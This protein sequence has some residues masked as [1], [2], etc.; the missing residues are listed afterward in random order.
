MYNRRKQTEKGW[1]AS[2]KERKCR[3]MQLYERKLMAKE[4]Q[5]VSLQNK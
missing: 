3:Y 1:I 2:G 5:I 4:Y